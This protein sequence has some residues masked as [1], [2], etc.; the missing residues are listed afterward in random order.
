MG[1]NDDPV[2]LAINLLVRAGKVVKG[3]KDDVI[4][5]SYADKVTMGR[6]RSIATKGDP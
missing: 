1:L 5:D 4:N 2:A 3:A 6:I